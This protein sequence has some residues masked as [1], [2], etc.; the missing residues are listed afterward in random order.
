MSARRDCQLVPFDSRS[1]IVDLNQ[2]S[3]ECMKTRGDH[4]FVSTVNDSLEGKTVTKIYDKKPKGQPASN[5]LVGQ[6][7]RIIKEPY[8]HMWRY[9]AGFGIVKQLRCIGIFSDITFHEQVYG[10]R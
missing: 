1:E 6:F 9:G 5:F 4:Y 8:H 10:S 3:K 2:G 7:Y